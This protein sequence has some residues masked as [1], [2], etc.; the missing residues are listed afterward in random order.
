[1]RDRKSHA[2]ARISRTPW[3][4]PLR[5]PFTVHCVVIVLPGSAGLDQS[6]SAGYFNKSFA[7]NPRKSKCSRSQAYRSDAK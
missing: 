2:H 5:N 4:K 1:M 7:G 3:A 6:N